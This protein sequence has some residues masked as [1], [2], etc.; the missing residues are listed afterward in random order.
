M[1]ASPLVPLTTV[2][3]RFEAQVLV[4]RLGADGIVAALQGGDTVY[5]LPGPVDVLVEAERAP[6]ARQLLLADEV[7]AVFADGHHPPG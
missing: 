2:G 1:S 3:S 7:E 5:P 4:A 6:D